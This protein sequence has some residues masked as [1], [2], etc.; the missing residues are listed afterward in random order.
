MPP[1]IV[2]LLAACGGTASSDDAASPVSADA[3]ATATPAVSL[4][5]P[6]GTALQ[7]NRR[8]DGLERWCDK[9]GVQHGPY[10]RYYPDGSR[11]VSGAWENNQEDGLWV[12]WHENGQ[13]LSRGRYVKG[14]K[15][16]SWSWYH[17][18]GN[19]ER[20]GDFLQGREAGLWTAWYESGRRQEEGLY[21]NG[22]KN[23]V[24]SFYLDDEA[25]TLVRTETWAN[26]VSVSTVTTPTPPS[27]GT[28]ADPTGSAKPVGSK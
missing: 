20:E 4:D 25:N 21:H 24:W 26:G 28:P 8:D 11:A 13:E 12:W 2:S 15:S 3:A 7:E 27:A 9:M 16:G 17:A 18:N 1:W 19:R 14:R 5:C 23:G 22:M 10:V 6:D